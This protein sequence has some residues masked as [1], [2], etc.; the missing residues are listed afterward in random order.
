MRQLTAQGEANPAQPA[1]SSRPSWES[2]TGFGPSEKSSDG[3]QTGRR[4]SVMDRRRRSPRD[5]RTDLAAVIVRLELLLHQT[6]Q[7]C[8]VPAERLDSAA[9]LARATTCLS[10]SE[11][12]GPTDCEVPSAD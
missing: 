12:A 3:E 10:S 11:A 4:D 1:V 5:V 9:S 7:I 2:D 8:C 6:Q